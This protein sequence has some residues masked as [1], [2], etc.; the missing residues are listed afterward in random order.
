MENTNVKT[1][2]ENE[3]DFSQL[4]L[5]IWSKIGWV[6]LVAIIMGGVTYAYCKYVATPM[7]QAESSLF[8]LSRN[9]DEALTT[10]D[11]SSSNALISDYQYFAT[12]RRVVE[13]VIE[14]LGLEDKYTYGQLKSEISVAIP[15]DS[16]MLKLIVTDADPEL[17]K[18]LADALS[19]VMVAHISQFMKA[20]VQPF[21]AAQLPKAPSSPTTFR[22]SVIAA[23]F[24]AFLTIAIIA[25]VFLLDDTI[26]LEEDVERTLKLPVLAMLPNSVDGA[27]VEKSKKSKK[28]KKQKKSG[29][30]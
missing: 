18:K 11:I 24:G 29:G 12:S 9:S 2:Q 13:Q 30:E 26:K 17:A 27:V 5:A 8:V 16:R 23:L 25:V 7:Y 10:S 14:K 22:N 20:D 1:V 19:E 21:E 3:I 6:I 4:L 15:T 28:S